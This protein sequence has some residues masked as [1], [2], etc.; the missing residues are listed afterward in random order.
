MPVALDSR[1]GGDRLLRASRL[2]P[3]P[4]KNRQVAFENWF[5]R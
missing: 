4:D 3:S 1:L 5:Q 2:D